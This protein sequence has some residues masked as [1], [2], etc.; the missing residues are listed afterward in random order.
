L[1]PGVEACDVDPHVVDPTKNTPPISR[2]FRTT[3]KGDGRGDT[4]VIVRRRILEVPV[5]CSRELPERS[6]LRLGLVVDAIEPDNSLKE[7][8]Q[9]GMGRRVAG[10][11]EEGLEEVCEPSPSEAVSLRH[12]EKRRKVEVTERGDELRMISWKLLMRPPAL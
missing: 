10:D 5:L 12:S 7:D 6:S 11:F 2:T 9:L 1:T 4:P 3:R 8:V